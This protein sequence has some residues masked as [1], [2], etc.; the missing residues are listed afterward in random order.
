MLVDRAPRRRLFILSGASAVVTILTATLTF[1]N[2][3]NYD[4]A[5]P[6]ALLLGTLGFD[7]AA[8]LVGLALAFVGVFALVAILPSASRPANSCAR[9]SATSS[10]WRSR[11]RTSS[12][13]SSAPPSLSWRSVA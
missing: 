5:L 12:Q 2:T 10:T 6:P 4:G 9:P 1:F 7:V 13:E 3:S 11:H 8:L